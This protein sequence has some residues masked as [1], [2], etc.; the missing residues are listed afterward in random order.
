MM[1]ICSFTYFSTVSKNRKLIFIG[2]GKRALSFLE[3]YEWEVFCC[4]DNNA[5]KQ[6]T[7]MNVQGKNIPIHSWDYLVRS[8]SP[9]CILLITPNDFS[10]L[11]ERIEGDDLLKAC[12]CY[13]AAYMSAM[14]WDE[15]RIAASNVPF[16]ITKGTIPKIPKIIHYFWFSGDPYPEKVQKCIDSWHKYC[17]DYEF[18][19]WDLNNYKTDCNYA[20]MALRQHLWAAAS[21]FCR[22]DVVYRYGGIYLDTDVELVKPLDDLLYDKGFFCFESALG[23]DPGSGFG[24]EKGN[25]IIKEICHSYEKLERNRVYQ[26]T[27]NGDLERVNILELY[28]NI[29][30]SHGL[31]RTGSY[32]VVDGIA[33]YPP[34][35][36]SP[37]SYMTGLLAPYDKTY[38]IHH[39]I[40]AWVTEKFMKQMNE[41][42][43]FI[44]KHLSRD[45]VQGLAS[46]I[47]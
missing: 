32:Q 2:A 11:L 1:K 7:Y 46:R 19:K 38:G 28:T 25:P 16:T 47:D 30:V 41:R 22:C 24:A 40:S 10:S 4:I 42:K 13:I 26:E 23:V 21:D 14:Q 3:K 20:N 37:Y 12:D 35:V 33:V 8:I 6:G 36:L 31:K 45:Y 27:S 17:P 29:L 39:W 5:G 43:A 18:K 44:Q 9:D 15:D 34:L